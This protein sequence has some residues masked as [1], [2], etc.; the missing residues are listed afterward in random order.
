[1]LGPVARD[2]LATTNLFN[3]VFTAET[4]RAVTVFAAEWSD[5]D[6]RQMSVV[7]HTPDVCWVGAGWV[8]AQGGQ[9]DQVSVEVS[10]RAMT[11]ECRLFQTP[12]MRQQELVLWSTLV[13]GQAMVESD[14]WVAEREGGLDR[15]TRFV[16]AGRRMAASQFLSNVRHR[17]RATA[18]KQFVRLSVPV[19]GTWQEGLEQLR[20]FAP[21]W[22][23]LRTVPLSP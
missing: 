12:G 4:G 15:D 16:L 7:Q 3:G 23:D 6:S 18:H 2:I 19:S 13:G 17:R 11:F 8:P 21:A 20:A 10:G 9:P 1:M 5:R 14:R 22:L